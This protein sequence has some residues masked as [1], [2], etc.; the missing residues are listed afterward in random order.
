MIVTA[1]QKEKKRKRKALS[2]NLNQRAIEHKIP[3]MSLMHNLVKQIISALI[4]VFSLDYWGKSWIQ[5]R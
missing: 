5:A 3:S 2:S 1:F 4:C